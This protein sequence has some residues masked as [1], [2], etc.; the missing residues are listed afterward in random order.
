[1]KSISTV[2]KLKEL[3]NSLEVVLLEKKVNKHSNL[4][5]NTYLNEIESCLM[6]LDS[7]DIAVIYF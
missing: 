7:S 6:K 3:R 1:M 5:I 4:K 2:I